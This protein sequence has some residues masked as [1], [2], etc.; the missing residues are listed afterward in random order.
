M[1]SFPASISDLATVV[2]AVATAVYT[3]GTF[4]LWRTTRGAVEATKASLK[5]AQEDLKNTREA[6][7]LTVL[8]AYLGEPRRGAPYEDYDR[9]YRRAVIERV[10]PGVIRAVQERAGQVPGPAG[11]AMDPHRPA[12][13]H[14]ITESGSV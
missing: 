13:C 8:L 5:I 7:E 12:P 11:M 9:E 3:I 1:S 4:L 14:L 6:H 10:F 2:T